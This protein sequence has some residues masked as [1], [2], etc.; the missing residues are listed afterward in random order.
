MPAISSA[1]RLAVRRTRDGEIVASRAAIARSPLA[2]MRGLLG[3]RSL[4]GG[5]GLLIEP[6][7]S[8]HT[9][10]M[11]FAIDVVF[12]SREGAVARVVC[13]LGRWRIAACRDACKVLELPAGRAQEIGL[14]VGDELRCEVV[15]PS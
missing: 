11:R 10:A 8:V 12:L 13:G 6:C 9:F 7:S 5:E 15:E 14:M 4:A 3:R 2:R 1:A